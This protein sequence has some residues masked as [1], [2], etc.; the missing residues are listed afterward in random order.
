MA[1]LLM[2]EIVAGVAFLRGSGFSTVYAATSAQVNKFL[3]ENNAIDVDPNSSIRVEFNGVVPLNNVIPPSSIEIKG[4]VVGGATLPTIQADIVTLSNSSSGTST[5]Y[6]IKLPVGQHLA[7]NT[8]YEIT[9]PAVL[10]TDA[11]ITDPISWSFTTVRQESNVSVAFSAE[12]QTIDLLGKNSFD[13]KLSFSALVQK[14]NGKIKIIKKSDSTVRHEVDVLNTSVQLS[15][16]GTE[17]TV[18]I[19]NLD[20]M[21]KEEGTQYDV[22]ID[23]GAFEDLNGKLIESKHG[24][25]ATKSQDV[26][27]SSLTPSKDGVGVPIGTTLQ[28]S[29]DRVMLLGSGSVIVSPGAVNDSRAMEIPIKLSK[30]DN[31]LTRSIITINLPSMLMY[32]TAYTVTIPI[33]AYKDTNNNSSPAIGGTDWVFRTAA[34]TVLPGSVSI[35]R[36]SPSNGATSVGLNSELVMNFNNYIAFRNGAYNGKIVLRQ[37][38]GGTVSISTPIISGNEIRFKPISSLASDSSYYVEIAADTLIDKTNPNISFPGLTGSS[39][40]NFQTIVVD[41][42]LPVLQSAQMY[43]NTTI[44]LAYNKTLEGASF[45]YASNFTVTVNNE[46]RRVSSAY[47]TGESVYVVLEVGVAVGQNVQISYSGGVGNPIQDSSL[48]KA[49]PF[50]N[51]V[52]TNGMDTAFPKPKEGTVYGS[53]L[54]L[55][56]NESLKS[57]SSYSYEQFSVTANGSS[58]GV[59]SISQSGSTLYLTLSNSISDGDVVRISYR[60]GSN[61]IQDQRGQNIAEF[62]DFYVRNTYDTKPPIF[63]GA[64]GS[65]TKIIMKYNEALKSSNIP[66]KNQ[67]SVLVNNIPV[68]VTAIQILDDN[69]Q[70]TLASSVSN[71]QNVTI[72]YVQGLGS[73]RITDLNNNPASYINLEPVNLTASTLVPEVRSATVKGDTLTLQFT[74]SLTGSLSTTV[75]N[76]LFLVKVDNT[77]RAVQSTSLSGNTVTLRLSSLVSV[78][79]KVQVSFSPG[80]NTIKDSQGNIIPTFSNLDVQNLTNNEDAKPS[81]VG[82]LNEGDFGRMMYLLDTGATT[83]S[84]GKSR[85]NQSIKQYKIDSR[86]LIA[87]YDYVA[88][89]N[90]DSKTIVFDVPSSERAAYVGIP[91]QSLQ[92]AYSKDKRV[93]FAV[94]IGD[95]IYS[96][97]IGSFNIS[98]ITRDLNSS[99]STIMIWVQVEKVP[100]NAVSVILNQMSQVGANVIVETNDFYV[101]AENTASGKSIPLNVSS[102]Y[103]I[104]TTKPVSESTSSLIYFDKSTAQISFVPTKIEKLSGSTILHAKVK[105]NYMVTGVTG[106]K[107]YG[108]LG[109]HWARES[110]NE[111]LVK[112]IVDGRTSIAFEPNSNITRG[113]FAVYIAK[114]LGLSGDSQAAERFRDVQ[115]TT[116]T[117]AYIGAATKA[118]IIT[119]NTDGTFKTNN[120]I[121]REQMS[122]M[123]VRAM[124]Y[125]GY[126]STDTS[127]PTTLSKF[128]D[129][130]KIQSLESVSRAVKEGII[131]GVSSTSFQPQGN[132]TRAQ[133]AV[134]LKRLLNTIG[135]L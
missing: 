134:M 123:M 99:T 135:Y 125:A 133:A 60:M 72:S 82:I 114:A 58:V 132:A 30:I 111:L 31:T 127:T 110:I 44:R 107:F 95:S 129:R 128:K 118:G 98:E 11:G 71:G 37:A 90:T 61:P 64:E 2:F 3:P 5:V 113:E 57:P 40:W 22:W 104:R 20:E 6:I 34:S 69:V 23:R 83:N 8:K 103:L 106:S 75:L 74:N 39:L 91:L 48:N 56:F 62:T 50:S 10:F 94:K 13:F 79:Q 55:S 43:S 67:L 66:A 24:T 33:G 121:T 47:I 51:R 80:Y 89:T 108:D 15:Q 35:S 101:S 105:G 97:P 27:I 117:G 54:S 12:G 112:F 7:Y 96:V 81:N 18:T 26:V 38:G 70:L 45:P 4:T 29:F 9:I 53:S 32:D 19:G 16:N 46:N 122:I 131:Q 120:Y 76:T 124:D 14:G 28:L 86:R 63:M 87:A 1:A 49:A 116:A 42:T 109:N 130:S 100:T 68:Y 115:S 73:A 52:V 126:K 21:K 77:T 36:L 102:E 84:D 93:Q 59:R 119:G 65:G 78:G 85:Y 17:A 92:D 41:K 88:T 25:F